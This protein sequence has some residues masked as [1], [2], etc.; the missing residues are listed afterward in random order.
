MNHRAVLKGMVVGAAVAAVILGVAGGLFV[1]IWGWNR[2]LADLW[3]LDNSRVGPNLCASVITVV[4]ITA[5]NEYRTIMK[6]EEHHESLRQTAQDA[7]R[8]ALHP[9][10]SAEA[11]IAADMKETP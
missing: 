3:P 5:H 9:A 10:E 1:A 8:E 11:A 4:L 7:I 2:L 6:A